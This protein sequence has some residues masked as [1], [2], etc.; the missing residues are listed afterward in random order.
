MACLLAQHLARR[1]DALEADNRE[2]R[3]LLAILANAAGVDVTRL[4]LLAHSERRGGYVS[5]FE[6]AQA[7]GLHGGDAA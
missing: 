7:L 3:E 5:T 4:L 1:V 2:L 6:E